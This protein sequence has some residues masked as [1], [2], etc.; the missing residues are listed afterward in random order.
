MELTWNDSQFTA[1]V[2]QPN[3]RDIDIVDRYATLCGLNKAEER[4][5]KGTLATARATED[6]N[7]KQ[8]SASW[9]TTKAPIGQNLF[10]RLDLEVQPVQNIRKLRLEYNRD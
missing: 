8:N 5:S 7:L 2:G 10:P 9:I 3:L 1:Q 4:Q 6:S